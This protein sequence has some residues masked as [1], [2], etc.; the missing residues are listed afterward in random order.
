MNRDAAILAF[1]SAGNKGDVA[2]KMA[3][4]LLESMPP[5]RLHTLECELLDA[6]I[7]L[8]GM[9]KL[10]EARKDALIELFKHVDK[11]KLD[12]TF[13]HKTQTELL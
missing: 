3:D 1:I 10:A 4:A 13:L 9:R 7:E 6:R 8:G 2:I 12:H 11:K 5:S